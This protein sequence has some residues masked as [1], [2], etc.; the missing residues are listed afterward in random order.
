MANVRLP[1]DGAPDTPSDPWLVPETWPTGF[2]EDSTCE[3]CVQWE[4][5]VEVEV[6]QSFNYT[7][8][9]FDRQ[10]VELK[11]KIPGTDL[12]TC[13]GVHGLAGEDGAPLTD[14]TAEELLLAGQEWKL[15]RRGGSWLNAVSL[16]KDI[17]GLTNLQ[18]NDTCV[19]SIRI[20]RVPIAYVVKGILST[21][22]V[23]G[24]SLVTALLLHPEEYIGDRSAVLFI[25]FLILI[26]NMQMDLG[27]GVISTLLWVDVFNLIQLFLVIVVIIETMVVH[28]MIRYLD[29]D[30]AEAAHHV[31]HVARRLLPLVYFIVTGV[32]VV[33]GAYDE[34]RMAAA[35]IAGVIVPVLVFF[36]WLMVRRLV[37]ATRAAQEKAIVELAN[38]NPA[39]SEAYDEAIKC[40]FY[41][42]DEDDSGQLGL[43]EMRDLVTMLHPSANKTDVRKAMLEARKYADGE[44][45][46]DLSNFTDALI[47][48][49]E[50]M[51]S[52]L[53]QDKYNEQRRSVQ[54]GEIST[55]LQKRREEKSVAGNPKP[56]LI[57][58]LSGL[59][60]KKKK[61]E[62]HQSIGYPSFDSS[63]QVPVPQPS[64]APLP[65]PWTDAP[66]AP[67]TQPNV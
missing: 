66:S 52:E 19:M 53:G 4:G 42:F 26:T 56:S 59:S 22:L 64:G 10:T 35:V 8:Y 50:F 34:Y 13:S 57:S 9:P 41:A 47:V 39:D 48:V 27:L 37:R 65:P 14:S 62:D 21:V 61:M 3:N 67:P 24:G 46:L 28:G 49:D 6:L 44:G 55:A 29:R 12:Y 40:V 18:K 11:F 5:G 25:A 7:Y 16:E 2:D 15:D 60:P 32:L 58:K 33:C 36:G 1:R 38:V 63:E 20:I 31:D 43:H 51:R 17:D 54:I 45:E 30:W 23:V